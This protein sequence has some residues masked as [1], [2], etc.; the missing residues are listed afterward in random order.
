MTIALA[1]ARTFA[2]CAWAAAY[3]AIAIPPRWWRIMSVRK[4][5]SSSR[6]CV[7]DNWASSASVAIPGIRDEPAGAVPAVLAVSAGEPPPAAS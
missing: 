4:R 7:V 6:P 3:W 5:T 2:S 1:R